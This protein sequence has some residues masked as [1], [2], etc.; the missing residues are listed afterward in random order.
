MSVIP[1]IIYLILIKLLNI[2]AADTVVLLKLYN[3]LELP[4][5]KDSILDCNYISPNQTN[6]FDQINEV[7]DLK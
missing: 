1:I 6:I 3:A 2:E 7:N 4:F 5:L